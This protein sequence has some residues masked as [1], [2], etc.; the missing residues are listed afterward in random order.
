[1]RGGVW[2]ELHPTQFS[3]RPGSIPHFDHAGDFMFVIHL[4]HIIGMRSLL[5]GA[6]GPPSPVC[7]AWKV[8]KK[9]AVLVVSS[10]AAADGRPDRAFLHV[11][12]PALRAGAFR[13]NGW[14]DT[15]SRETL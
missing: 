8:A 7:R 14:C 1:M 6:A 3:Q 10:K 2:S 5:V 15:K 13:C 9:M 11:I 12:R 4:Q